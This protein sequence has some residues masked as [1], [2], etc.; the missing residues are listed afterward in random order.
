MFKI[1]KFLNMK[2]LPY[3]KIR[4]KT[5]I[6]PGAVIM[7]L[8]SNI[9]LK[10]TWKSCA[11]TD[12][13]SYFGEIYENSFEIYRSTVYRN[14]FAPVITGLVEPNGE[15]STIDIKMKMYKSVII[16]LCI[17][18]IPVSLVTILCSLL[19]IFSI[20]LGEEIN[21]AYLAPWIIFGA[22]YALVMLAFKYETKK[23]KE[24]IS[25]LFEA[26]IVE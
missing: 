9:D 22:G 8:R 25:E 13:Y 11:Y 16:F 24:Y 17:W 23:I 3:E 26:D 14:D 7:L 1:D 15:G 21:F 20:L 19:F 6:P 4:Y 5:N 18:F 12:G 10:N 2:Y